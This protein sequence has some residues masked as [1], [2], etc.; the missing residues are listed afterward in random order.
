MPPDIV[1]YQLDYKNVKKYDGINESETQQYKQELPNLEWWIAW[2]MK[3]KEDWIKMHDSL[4]ND[5][6]IF[7]IN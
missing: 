4:N 1:F 3:E 6:K 7:K 5:F 2:N